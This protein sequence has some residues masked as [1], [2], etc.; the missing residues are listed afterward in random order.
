MT[1]GRV[2]GGLSAPLHILLPAHPSRCPKPRIQ[3][4]RA[5]SYD[6]SYEI[7][8][9]VRWGAGSALWTVQRRVLRSLDVLNRKRCSH[10]II[11]TVP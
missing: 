7:A 11:I 6:Q 8:I 3:E 10:D 2:P 1:T 4:V 9:T 5:K